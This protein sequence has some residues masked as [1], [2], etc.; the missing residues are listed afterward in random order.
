MFLLAALAALLALGGCATAPVNP[1]L[2]HADPA[3]GYRYQNRVQYD[4]DKEDLVIL[5]FSGGGTRAAAFSYGVLEVLRD[6]EVVGKNGQR[7][8]M[9]DSV[10]IIAGVS[11]G[12][13]T[14]TSRRAGRCCG[15]F[16]ILRRSSTMATRT[17]RG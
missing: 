12:S 7:E 9:L 14:A 6:T 11:G 8:R 15:R 5:A 16:A 17:W 4:R 13:F 3:A 2:T 10:D 1:P